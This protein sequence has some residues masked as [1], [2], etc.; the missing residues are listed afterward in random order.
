M[1]SI[2]I[3][4]AMQHSA[5]SGAWVTLTLGAFLTMG[6]IKREDEK[7]TMFNSN[8]KGSF[9]IYFIL[10]VCIINLYILINIS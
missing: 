9:I 10:I 7:K 3:T 2:P 5:G 6:G 4:H 8:V 1:G